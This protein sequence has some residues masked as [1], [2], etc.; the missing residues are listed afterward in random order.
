MSPP[1]KTKIV[2]GVRAHLRAP[3]TRWSTAQV[4]VVVA[5]RWDAGCATTWP[6]VGAG[7]RRPVRAGRRRAPPGRLGR[8][9]PGRLVRGARG[10]CGGQPRRRALVDRRPTDAALAL[11]TASR[12]EPTLALAAAAGR[13]VGG[14]PVL[15]QVTTAAIH[16]DAGDAE[17]D[18]TSPVGA[19]PPQMVGVATAW[20]AAAA[21]VPA[22]RTVVLRTS[23]V[24]DRDT[25]ALDR[26]TGRWSGG[27]WAVRSTRRAAVG[28]LDPR[29]G[30]GSRCC[31]ASLGLPEPAWPGGDLDG[32]GPGDGAAPVR[33]AELMEG[34][35]GAPCTGPGLRRRPAP[36]VRLGS[37][38][39]RTDPALALTGRRALPRRLLDGSSPSATRSWR[40]RCRTCWGACTAADRVPGSGCPQEVLAAPASFDRE[41]PHEIGLVLHSPRMATVRTGTLVLPCSTASRAVI[42]RS[43]RVVERCTRTRPILL[44]ITMGETGL[45]AW[46]FSATWR[47]PR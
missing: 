23:V 12:V 3:G 4:K 24:L 8:R 33:N 19:G 28:Q 45:T 41:S 46:P 47:E 15:V 37:L 11:L 26:L 14:L 32:V 42:D 9:R 43:F 13:A 29:R 30:T 6:A 44:S 25:P 21:Q 38:L 10:Q 7:R 1:L 16:G 2:A 31:G 36:L 40:R 34:S 22:E 18:E 5:G 27:A 35:C 17:L 39:L 20:E